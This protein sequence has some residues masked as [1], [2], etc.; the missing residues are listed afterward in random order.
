MRGRGLDDYIWISPD[1]VVNVFPNQNTK[2][3]TSRDI[4]RGI[5]GASIR[6]LETGMD[7]RALHIGDWDGD[8][9]DDI[10][11]VDKATGSLT[12]WKSNW[13][14]GTDFAF[15]RSSIP[16]SDKCKQGWGVGYFDNG[17]HFA[18]IT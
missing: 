5:W 10:I 2:Q 9:R 6:A 12:V 14:S 18:D 8:G 17:I 11:G 7:R 4:T 13:V 3:D 1:G 15:T 16:N